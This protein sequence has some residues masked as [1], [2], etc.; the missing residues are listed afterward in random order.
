MVIVTRVPPLPPKRQWHIKLLPNVPL[1]TK[2]NASCNSSQ[3]QK[4]V[5]S[6]KWFGVENRANLSKSGQLTS[7]LEVPLNLTA[8]NCLILTQFSLGS[9]KMSH[10]HELY[11]PDGHHNPYRNTIRGL[12][13]SQEQEKLT[14]P[15][16]SSSNGH[17]SSLDFCEDSNSIESI[18][19]ATINTDTTATA[20]DLRHHGSFAVPTGLKVVSLVSMVNAS[21]YTR[22]L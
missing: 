12:I 16:T 8:T 5:Q 13:Q 1:L 14:L 10:S 7:L 18:N 11:G 9:L 2:I 17:S 19:S 6:I 20:K 15:S 21:S 3:I 22:I 4:Y